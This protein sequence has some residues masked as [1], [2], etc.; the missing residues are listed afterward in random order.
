MKTNQTQCECGS[1]ELYTLIG[2]YWVCKSCVSAHL[3]AKE[4]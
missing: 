1:K 2:D 3:K 4:K